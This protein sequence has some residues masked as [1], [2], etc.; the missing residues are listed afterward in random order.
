MQEY[1]LALLVV[2]QPSGEGTIEPVR[3]GNS[4]AEKQA[5]YPTRLLVVHSESMLRGRG[6]R[7]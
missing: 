7:G 4:F 5:S 1:R 2:V 6:R 3:R